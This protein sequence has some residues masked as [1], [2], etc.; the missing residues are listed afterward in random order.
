MNRKQRR[1]YMKRRGKRSYAAP[2]EAESTRSMQEA[3]KAL[4]NAIGTPEDLKANPMATIYALGSHIGHLERVT[5]RKAAET[6]E[7]VIDGYNIVGMNPDAAKLEENVD[8]DQ[9][10]NAT[11]RII[12]QLVT[13][14]D[15]PIGTNVWLTAMASILGQLAAM[16]AMPPESIAAIIITAWEATPESDVE[17]FQQLMGK[18]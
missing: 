15:V 4:T 1:A 14:R 2:K 6:I 13:P 8:L 18:Q 16:H 10:A 7:T 5:L 12:K 9:V 3:M 17:Q 11:N